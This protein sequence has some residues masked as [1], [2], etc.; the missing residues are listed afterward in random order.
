M[1]LLAQTA[2]FGR[3][4][5]K[6]TTVYHGT[7]SAEIVLKAQQY[8]AKIDNEKTTANTVTQSPVT[9]NQM[10]KLAQQR[11][12]HDLGDGACIHHHRQAPCP[13]SLAAPALSGDFYWIATPEE[14]IGETK[15]QIHMNEGLLDLALARTPCDPFAT[16]WVE[17]YK[18]R[19][20][21]L[22][23]SNNA[24]QHQ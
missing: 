22:K 23:A 18:F 14:A 10:K 15:R 3:L 7:T 17:H 6:Q 9:F 12:V 4:D 21:Q 19:L 1:P 8:A 13:H 2:W 24:E 11:P 20:N 16:A 5:P